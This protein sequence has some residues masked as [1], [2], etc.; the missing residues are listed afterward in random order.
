MAA[1]LPSSTSSFAASLPLQDGG[2]DGTKD[3]SSR[4]SDADSSGSESDSG[5]STRSG[6][7]LRE[8]DRRRSGDMTP[9]P[10]ISRFSQVPQLLHSGRPTTLAGPE[11]DIGSGIENEYSSPSTS[12][13][14]DS[15]RDTDDDSFDADILAAVGGNIGLAVTLIPYLHRLRAKSVQ[16]KIDNWQI[17]VADPVDGD[18]GTNGSIDSPESLRAHRGS[19]R[20]S[21]AARKRRHQSDSDNDQDEYDDDEGG[22]D[23]PDFLGLPQGIKDLYLACHFHKFDPIKYGIRHISPASSRKDKYRTCAGPG[24][25]TIQRL[26][27][28]SPKTLQLH[29]SLD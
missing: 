16:E 3:D 17:E 8:V 20:S 12:E 25:K 29:S 24:F 2:A 21:R 5:L 22:N 26:K 19:L 9:S 23:S 18:D 6:T 11:N 10:N 28:Q 4:Q 13:N 27:H 1:S 15:D 14:S 7:A